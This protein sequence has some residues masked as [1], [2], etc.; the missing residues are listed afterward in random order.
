MLLFMPW[1]LRAG[2]V[3]R[4]EHYAELKGGTNNSESEKKFRKG[5]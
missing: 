4:M 5:H 3:R 2:L 1:L